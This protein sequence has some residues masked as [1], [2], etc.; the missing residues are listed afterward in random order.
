MAAEE[1]MERL[2]FT[3]ESYLL[4]NPI[5]LLIRVAKDFGL[6][7]D[8]W[9]D[10]SK[11]HIIR[12]FRKELE[13]GTMD[14]RKTKLTGVIG[15]F[16]T[17]LEW[18]ELGQTV[19]AT[20]DIKVV[21]GEGRAAL[22]KK[23]SDL[24][25]TL[26][27]LKTESRDIRGGRDENKNSVTLLNETLSK[28]MLKKEFK[29]TG[30]IND[31]KRTDKPSL[32]YISLIHQIEAGQRQNYTDEEIISGV[33]KAMTPG[34]RL[35][36][37]FETLPNLKLPRV[38]LML[39]SH[40]SERS[41]AELFQLLSNSVQSGDESADEFLIKVYEIRQKLIFAR[42]ESGTVAVPFDDAL[43]QSV[44]INC[45]ETGISSEAI[46]NKVR[47][48]LPLPRQG[49]TEVD[50]EA[51]NDKLIHQMNIA[52][53][54][55]LE[56]TEKHKNNARRCTSVQTIGTSDSDVDDQQPSNS[57]KKGVSF[58]DSESHQLVATLQAIQSQLG[59]LRQDVNQ[60]RA[61]SATT[62][63][64]TNNR[65][66]RSRCRSC[67]VEKIDFC[68]HCFRCGSSEHFA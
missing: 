55:E 47:P 52:M 6:S 24:E 20:A 65:G 19:D 17:V 46:R 28:T 68:D 35:R 30:T 38:R 4:N 67:I 8:L 29:I 12:N 2:E 59:T 5:D 18:N 33:I 7:E 60:L 57:K 54:T 13:S 22:D 9:R 16:M 39:R 42:K 41:A 1:E 63:T 32:N 26:S 66:T 3:F 36:T 40:Y 51:V 49:E 44:F 53:S 37:V 21:Q 11:M 64:D 43:I 27:K 45:I 56:H 58:K 34:M 31:Q 62:T 61:N 10:K 50:F 25:E 48:Y 15:I 14:E 23:I